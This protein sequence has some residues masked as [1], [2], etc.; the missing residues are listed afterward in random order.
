MPEDEVLPD[1]YNEGRGALVKESLFQNP[2][3]TVKGKKGK[4][5]KKK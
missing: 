5:G 3:P 1:E 2:F 4:K